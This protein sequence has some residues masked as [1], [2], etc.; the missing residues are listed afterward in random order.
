ME[1]TIATHNRPKVDRLHNLR[2]PVRVGNESHINP[3]GEHETWLDVEHRE[4]YERLFGKAQ[5]EFNEKQKRKD[6]KIDDYYEHKKRINR[7]SLY[8][9]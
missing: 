1:V 5:L 4:A 7:K 9:K 8:M 6:R 2:D 3:S